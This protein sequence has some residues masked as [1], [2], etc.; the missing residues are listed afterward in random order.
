MSTR[1]CCTPAVKSV[2]TAIQRDSASGNGVDVV[3][4][5]EKEIKRV[6]HKELVC[7]L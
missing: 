3:V 7:N 6:M 5:T 4:V 2:N 1:G